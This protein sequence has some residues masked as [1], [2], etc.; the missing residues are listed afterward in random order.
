MSIEHKTPVT[1]REQQDLRAVQENEPYVYRKARER[2]GLKV[3]HALLE[4][5]SLPIT[6]M[7][8]GRFT[9]NRAEMGYTPFSI[10][11]ILARQEKTVI[12]PDDQPLEFG[13]TL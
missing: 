3:A 2:F 9:Q 5:E 13:G 11:E 12:I 1:E 4:T 10:A 8:Q 7:G 6:G